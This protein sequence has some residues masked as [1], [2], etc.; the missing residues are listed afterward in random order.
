M[1]VQPLRPDEVVAAKVR[2]LPDPILEV[3]NEAI[4]RNMSDG[5][6]TVLQNEVVAALCSKMD[7]TRQHVFKQGWLE[8]E[9]I[10]R[11]AGW[12]VTYDKPG[13]CETYEAFFVFTPK[14]K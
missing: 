1:P 3:W 9:A 12:K 8:I 14:R 2:L 5:S 13:Y 7:C 10:Y 11:E 6:S 4:A